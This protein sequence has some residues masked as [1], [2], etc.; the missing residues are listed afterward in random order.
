[1]VDKPNTDRLR[2]HMIEAAEQCGRTALP[3]VVEPV[4]LAAL[5]RDWPHGPHAVLRRRDGRRT[6]AVEAMRSTVPAPPR[7]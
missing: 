5:L 3:A 4:K 2:A 6:G 7:S 1:M